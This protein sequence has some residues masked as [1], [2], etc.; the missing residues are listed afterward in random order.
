M[1]RWQSS[2]RAR[3]PD[4]R[5]LGFT[6]LAVI[7]AAA[8]AAPIVSPYPVDRQFRG[9]LNAPPTAPHLRDDRGLWHPPFIYPLKLTNQLEQ[10][11]EED[12]LVVVPLRWLSG[13]RIVS[14]ADDDRMPLLLLGADSYGRD[15]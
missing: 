9:L 2:I 15:V 14:S 12:R 5:T 1:R 7:V 4:V 13:G 11:Y 10:R 8:V 3:P 6:L